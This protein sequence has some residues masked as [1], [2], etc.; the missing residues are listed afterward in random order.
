MCGG[1]VQ[2]SFSDAGCGLPLNIYAGCR[3]QLAS[4][5]AGSFQVLRP[6]FCSLFDVE[7]RD[8]NCLEV[9]LN[10]VKKGAMGQPVSKDFKHLLNADSGSHSALK[11]ALEDVKKG[12]VDC[13]ISNYL[14]SLIS[15]DS[16]NHEALK[17]ALDKVKKV[18]VGQQVPEMKMPGVISFRNKLCHNLLTLET[19]QF[20]ALV[21]CARSMLQGVC[22]VHAFIYEDVEKGAG[23]G[24]GEVDSDHAEESLAEIERILKR[25]SNFQGLVSTLSE[26][27]RDTVIQ[28]REQ[29]LEEREK[30][31]Q[32]LEQHERLKVK[33]GR[34]FDSFA[35]CLKKDIQDQLA[36]SNQIGESGGQGAVYRVTLWL[37]GQNLAVKVFHQNTEGDA[38]RRELNSLTFLTHANIVRMMYIV[39]ETLE[40]RNQC[41][42]PMGYAMELMARSAAVEYAYTLEQ[43]LKVFEQIASA[44]AFSHEHGVIHLDVK[45]ENI[46]LDESCSVAK[47]CDFGCAH[48]LHASVT[49][50]TLQRQVRGTLLYMAPEAFRDEFKDSPLNK[51]CDIYSFGKTMWKLLHPLRNVEINRAFPVVADVPSSLKKLVEQ[52]TMDDPGERPQEMSDVLKR[53]QRVSQEYETS[54]FSAT[55]TPLASLQ[56]KRRPMCDMTTYDSFKL[57]KFAA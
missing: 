43:L 30:R 7:C 28:L 27:E 32:M 56:V 48:M 49:A 23:A 14:I 20:D 53:L 19:Q 18:L 12:P 37:W 16:E 52:C 26:H 3:Y 1:L 40:D 44:L 11:L 57:T 31:E 35:P 38:W 5:E 47:L 6:S 21:A 9:A 8:I 36:K 42:A 4:I 54:M 50:S 41:R 39:Y 33:L 34:K 24:A 29:L 55:A 45:P 22:N 10:K 15:V 13:D 2:V 46:L 25:D 51:R 17:S